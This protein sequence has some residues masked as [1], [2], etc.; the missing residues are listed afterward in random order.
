MEKT[1]EYAAS[2]QSIEEAQE[3]I[4]SFAHITPLLTSSS[5]DGLSGRNLY[6]KCETFQKGSVYVTSISNL[7]VEFPFMCYVCV[8]VCMNVMLCYAMYECMNV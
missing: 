1:E 7:D 5:L 4:R 2:L 8:Y 3:R 6:F